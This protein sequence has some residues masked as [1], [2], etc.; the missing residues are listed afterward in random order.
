MDDLFK[1]DINFPV[2]GVSCLPFIKLL[3]IAIGKEEML[4]KVCVRRT[5]LEQA[6]RIKIIVLHIHKTNRNIN[7]QLSHKKSP[8]VNSAGLFLFN[9]SALIFRLSAFGLLRKVHRLLLV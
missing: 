7:L 9:L 5:P 6:W 3:P 2:L 4:L 1:T 8:Q